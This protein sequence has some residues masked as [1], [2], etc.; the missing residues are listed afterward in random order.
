MGRG[1]T[2]AGAVALVG[3]AALV[4]GLIGPV[5]A[6]AA[7]SVSPRSGAYTYGNWAQVGSGF[8]SDQVYTILKDDTGT[9]YATGTF[10]KS[11]DD[12]V[13]RVATYSGSAWTDL[14]IDDSGV[15]PTV[16][17]TPAGNAAPWPPAYPG[18]YGSALSP[19]GAL[20]M[21][22]QFTK[23]D[24]TQ[25]NN[26][27][28]WTGSSWQSMAYGLYNTQSNLT[29]N[30]DVV[31]NLVVAADDSNY[32]D[33]TVYAL[34]EFE[35]ICHNTT[36]TSRTT[37]ASKGDLAQWV[38]DT[39]LPLP[40]PLSGMAT[41]DKVYTGA[42]LDD[43]SAVDGD[44]TVYV[45]G[46]F[47]PIGSNGLK[48]IAAWNPSAGTWSRLG[49]GL[50]DGGFGQV[51]AMTVHPVTK[52]LFV[53]G[54]FTA[55]PGGRTDLYSV[56]KWDYLDDTWYSVGNFTAVADVASIAISPN[57]EHLYIGGRFANATAGGSSTPYNRIAVLSGGDLTAGA[58]DVGGTWNYLKSAGAIG[59]SASVR[60]LIANNDG[61]VYVAGDFTTAGPINAARVALFTP[62]PEP[63]PNVPA[64]PP[65]PPLNVV[66]KGGWQTVT[67]SWDPPLDQGTYPITNYLAQ[68][69]AVGSTPAGNVCIT[70]LTDAK[71]TECTFTSLKPGVQYTFT[72]QGL[73][74]GGWGTRSEASNIATPYELK[75]T[76]YGRKKLSFL[77]IPLGSEVS[78]RGTSLGYPAGTRISVFIKEGDTGQWV[79]Q[80]N[81]GLSTNA[82]GN[83]SWKRKF[84]PKKDRTPISV[85]FGIG[86]DR[87]NVVRIPPVR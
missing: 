76:G 44:D 74:G 62:G 73:N 45:G 66:A 87:S 27:A 17:T 12:T 78:A 58:T 11:G 1:S 39:W 54:Y 30:A 60:S 24:D 72:V 82:S 85:Q 69:T 42:Y 64:T 52:D 71:L 19:S 3:S 14:G 20:Y 53:A 40:S 7:P 55:E 81:S 18:V 35:G 28:R 68:A 83:F 9:L 32:A 8:G 56:A 59:V 26:V 10:R 6:T 23:I 65:G 34:G 41:L 37:F 22:G 48:N 49:G 63:D 25:V 43:S 77:R 57:G 38:D 4:A 31:E 75:I 80:R 33:D 2:A 13:N 36:C 29:T 84:S 5:V 15:D 51:A 16:S 79:E 47:S 21:G 46:V 50:T 61:S 67:V 86:D 70:R